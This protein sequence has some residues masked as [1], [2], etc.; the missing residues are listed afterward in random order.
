MY[1][2]IHALKG[3]E[4]TLHTSIISLMR[5]FNLLT[6]QLLRDPSHLVVVLQ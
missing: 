4:G 1:T 6:I 2:D 3:R 5:N